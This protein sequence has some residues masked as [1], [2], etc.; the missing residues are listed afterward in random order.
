MLDKHSELCQHRELTEH[1]R[2]EANRTR[3]HARMRA[4]VY[5]ASGVRRP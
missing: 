2:I 5:A 4:T 3:G 1:C